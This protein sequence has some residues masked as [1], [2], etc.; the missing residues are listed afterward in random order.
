MIKFFRKIRQQMIKENRV[1]KYILYAIGEILLV[2]IGI[3]IALQF[4]AWNIIRINDQK[5]INLL[6]E[7][8]EEYQGK[9][10]ELEQK[11][12][13]RNMMI[14]A[15]GSLLKLI[16][17]E[18]FSIS[19]DS[20]MRLTALTTISPTFDASNSVTEEL[21]NTGNLYLIK[22]NELRKLTT[23]WKGELDKMTEEED[24]VIEVLMNDYLPY[25]FTKVPY[26]SMVNTFFSENSEVWKYIMKSGQDNSYATGK[27]KQ[28]IDIEMLL[29]DLRFE[30]YATLI[31]FGSLTANLQSESLKTHI[32]TVL[33]LI[34]GDLKQ[35]A[36]ND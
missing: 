25:L 15:S 20:L 16:Q 9:L 23:E 5:E 2:V 8:K 19:Y 4:N 6:I 12:Q 18:N 27:S 11:M 31:N 35:K 30:N 24:R 13:L 29:K 32:N 33:T 22:N 14:S 7:L 28:E 34:D 36:I 3:L 21:I 17:E 10:I 26:K 1:S